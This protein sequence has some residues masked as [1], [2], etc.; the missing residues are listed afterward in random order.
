MKRFKQKGFTLIELM[1]VVA[2]I[3]VLAAIAVPQYQNYIKKSQ[4]AEVINQTS[5]IKI[6]DALCMKEY[7]QKIGCS[8]GTNNVIADITP[9]NKTKYTLSVVT[10]DGVITATARGANDSAAIAA[11]TAAAGLP[12]APSAI[13]SV[14]PS[15]PV[16]YRYSGSPA[17]P[18]FSTPA[19]ACSDWLANAYGGF[20][21]GNGLTVASV[22]D[23]TLGVRNSS[24][25]LTSG[26]S[27]NPAPWNGT[28]YTGLVINDLPICPTPASGSAYTYNGMTNMCER[29]NPNPPA[30]STGTGNPGT[31]LTNETYILTPSIDA[32]GG[33]TYTVGG[34][35]L[36]AGLCAP[37]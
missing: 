10:L 3:G 34:T 20:L 15:S 13:E 31:A 28:V 9:L 1:V 27:T 22:I 32:N 30:P 11:A 24:G 5:A 8:G 21:G 36:A 26:C 29:P 16:G 23:G 17:L 19:A 25:Q 37:Q 14:A 18:V 6:S 12:A 4:F 35:C 2:V 33:I 7:N